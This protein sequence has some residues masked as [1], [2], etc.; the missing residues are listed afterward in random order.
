MKKRTLTTGSTGKWPYHAGQRA[1]LVAALAILGGTALP[2]AVIVGHPV[3]GSPL[4][5]TATLWAGLMTLAGA[6]VRWKPVVVAS[7]AAG[8]ATAVFLA[9]WQTARLVALCLSF[10]CLPGPGLGLLLIGGGAAVYQAV[11]LASGGRVGRRLEAT[12]G[13]LPTRPR[14]SRR[15]PP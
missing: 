4:A 8:G 3:W 7:L 12:R 15:R 6:A 14:S 2:W 1:M 5:L 10:Q 11:E 13:A 9:V